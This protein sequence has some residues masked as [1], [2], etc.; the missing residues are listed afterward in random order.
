[1]WYSIK[2]WNIWNMF[3][4]YFSI[5]FCHTILEIDIISIYMKFCY[6]EGIMKLF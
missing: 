1:M 4:I 6:D 5:H 3:S 2:N